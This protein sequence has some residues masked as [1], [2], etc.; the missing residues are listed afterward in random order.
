MDIG[1]QA[2]PQLL[3][4]EPEPSAPGVVARD[5]LDSTGRA[6]TTAMA[7][8][9]HRVCSARTCSGGG[10]RDPATEGPV[11]TPARPGVP[12]GAVQTVSGTRRSARTRSNSDRKSVV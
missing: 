2:I 11:G 1:H 8:P 9:I 7:T 12:T 10:R 6:I 5:L 4:P 3:N